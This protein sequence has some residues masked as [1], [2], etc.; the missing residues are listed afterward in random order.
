MGLESSYTLGKLADL[1][2]DEITQED[3]K[4]NQFLYIIKKN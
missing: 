1:E 3:I 4:K 2:D